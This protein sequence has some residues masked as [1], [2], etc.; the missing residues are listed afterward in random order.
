LGQFWVWVFWVVLGLVLRFGSVFG[1][2]VLGS[3]GFG[4]AIWVSIIPSNYD[5][6]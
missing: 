3:F 5:I 2:G 4:F 6:D 1:L